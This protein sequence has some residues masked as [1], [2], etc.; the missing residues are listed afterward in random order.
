MTTGL[1]FGKFKGRRP[2]EIPTDY[3][4]WCVNE[5]DGRKPYLRHAIEEELDR[6]DYEAQRRR[7]EQ[8]EYRPPDPPPGTPLVDVGRAVGEW[9][10]GLTLKYHP[11]RGGTHE[12]MLVV[13]EAHERLRKALHLA[14]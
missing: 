6:R 4:V 5:L 10:R 1:T 13:N 11:D 7:Y 2:D 14:N 12:Q 8:Q 3:L 9:Y